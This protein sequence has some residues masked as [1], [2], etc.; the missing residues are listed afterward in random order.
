MLSS[1]DNPT[2]FFESKLSRWTD[3]HWFFP[4]RSDFNANLANS[5]CS[6]KLTTPVPRSRLLSGLRH[7][8][9]QLAMRDFTNDFQSRQLR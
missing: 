8:D 4:I 9:R 2:R 3:L 7:E 5:Y 6:A 1:I